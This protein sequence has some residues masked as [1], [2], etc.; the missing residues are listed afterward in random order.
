MKRLW[1]LL[2]PILLVSCHFTRPAPPLPAPAYDIWVSYLPETDQE[3]QFQLGV[4]PIPMDNGWTDLRMERDLLRMADCRIRVVML[5][6]TSAQ[7]IDADFLNRVW[8]FC[9]LAQRKQLFVVPYLVQDK[10]NPV[11]FERGNL[12]RYL[13]SLKFKEIPALLQIQDRNAVLVSE[14]FQLED[15]EDGTSEGIALLRFG[16]ELPSRPDSFL[17]ETALLPA[18]YRWASAGIYRDDAWQLKRQRGNALAKQLLQLRTTPPRV[19]LLDS[20]NDYRRGSFMEQNSL[21]GTCMTKA[22]KNR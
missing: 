2:F 4:R 14:A 11:V 13:E 20:W 5:Q 18:E 22:V 9:E 10:E 3:A 15:A 8:K 6:L 21:D 17:P 7:L 16:K 1:L 12:L 19:L